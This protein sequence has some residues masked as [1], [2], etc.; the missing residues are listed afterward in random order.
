MK[1][2]YTL[3]S[4]SVDDE[5]YKYINTIR[6]WSPLT[7][8]NDNDITTT[9]NNT[10]SPISYNPITTNSHTSTTITTTNNLNTKF[11]KAYWSSEMEQD[12]NNF[13]GN[14]FNNDKYIDYRSE[15]YF[16][17]TN[18]SYN[19]NRGYIATCRSL[20][21]DNTQYNRYLTFILTSSVPA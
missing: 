10:N 4:I 5:N 2:N 6:A 3:D 15:Q 12:L 9:T 1:N 7:F 14:K 20:H 16:T 13:H 11:N 18:I 8:N 17:I 21:D 19:T